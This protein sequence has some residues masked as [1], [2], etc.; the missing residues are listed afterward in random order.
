MYERLRTVL[1]AVML[2]TSMGVAGAAGTASAQSATD[3]EATETAQTAESNESIN[4][5]TGAQLSTVLAAT[6]DDVV[7]EYESSVFETSLASANE[8]ERAAVLADRAS[9]IQREATA[10]QNAYRNTTAQL[11]AGEISRATY[12]QRLATLHA[13]AANVQQ[14]ARVVS[15]RLD[16]VSAFELR[17]AGLNRSA[18]DR[19]VG[20][21]EALSGPGQAALFQQFAGLERGEVR[22]QTAGGLRVEVESEDGEQSREIRR[23]GDESRAFT[24]NQSAALETARSRLSQGS[25][26]WVLTR[27]S[28]HGVDGQYRFRFERPASDTEAEARV[29]VD[30]SSGDAVRLEESIERAD[31]SEEQADDA[32]ATELTLLVH[33]G[34]PAPNATITVQARAGGES[35]EDLPI[36]LDGDRVGTTDA[37]GSVAIQLPADDATLSAE[38]ADQEAEL[39]FEFEEREEEQ[40]EG[41]VT[42]D[43]SLAGDQATLTV[44]F[45]GAPV[46]NLAVAVEGDPVGTTDANGTVAFEAPTE[47]FEVELEQRGFDAE[48]TYV[49]GDGQLVTTEPLEVD[50]EDDESDLED[51]EP[52]ADDTPEADDDDTP[53]ADDDDTPEGTEVETAEPTEVETAEPTETETDDDTP[54]TESTEA[55]SDTPAPADVDLGASL[56]DGE[57]TLTLTED[58]DGI[59]GADASANSDNIGT[60]AADGT[61]SFAVSDDESEYDVRLETE[62]LDV[63]TTYRVENGSLTQTDEL[64]VN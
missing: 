63:R 40:A 31:D 27:A 1:F 43:T 50:W 44:A 49:R 8:S 38:R 42:I 22:L 9:E 48:T 47:A 34:S 26:P 21:L 10:I 54:E 25:A 56:S 6:S 2:V 46:K 32:T 58:G 3:Q 60:T 59:S 7:T 15:A 5:S 62:T 51:G 37:N 14:S 19:S 61:V 16:S 23:A 33:D 64:E 35:V 41:N 20:D 45:D 55:D 18:Y 4:V 17:A 28:V 29:R 30:G 39:E 57:V 53:E 24:V 11:G 52:V 12:A 13:R 36:R